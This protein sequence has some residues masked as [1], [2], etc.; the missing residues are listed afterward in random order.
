MPDLRIQ[1]MTHA[2][3]VE[4]LDVDLS[5]L[6]EAAFAQVRQ[7]FFDHAVLFVRDQKLTPEQHIEFAERWGEINVNRFFGAVQDHP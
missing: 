7:A 5:D 2:L 3:G 6:T 4:I 1:R